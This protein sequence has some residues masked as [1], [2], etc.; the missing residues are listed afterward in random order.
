MRPNRTLTA[1]AIASTLG[2]G[3]GVGLS[4]A[5]GDDPPPVWHPAPSATP[6]PATDAEK[7]AFGV[8][9]AAPTAQDQAN[10][11]VAALA[12]HAGVGFDA[13]GARVV[14]STAA[15]P[16][17]LIPVNGGL[18]LGLQDSAGTA[19]GTA[20]E[21]GDDVVARGTTIGDG[22]RI[23]GIVPDDATAVTVTPAGGAP[24]AVNVTPGGT[25]ALPAQDATVG[26]TGPGGVTEF[27][28]TG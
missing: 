22:T 16:I 2:L 25:Y 6:V 28:V 21:A 17:W 19:L 12:A 5:G 13:G 20:C 3:A 26:V 8:L 14:G 9:A 7:A 18:C 27:G 24:S 10:A 11:Q 15:G 1:I 23:Y 4:Q